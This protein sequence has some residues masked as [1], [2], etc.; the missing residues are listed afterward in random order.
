M[1]YTV[2]ISPPAKTQIKK[3]PEQIQKR[4]VA[5][6]RDLEF[7]PR[8]STVEKLWSNDNLYRVRIGDYRII[9]QI[10]DQELTIIIAKVA[11]RKN[12]YRRF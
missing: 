8:P 3:L 11:H 7:I 5:Q 10:N 1:K 2:R 12:I 4:I 6:I 9:Y